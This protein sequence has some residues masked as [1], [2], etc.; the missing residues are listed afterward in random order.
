[1]LANAVKPLVQQGGEQPDLLMREPGPAAASW[2]PAGAAVADA[3]ATVAARPV[4]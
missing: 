1:M 2:A 3:A 4:P